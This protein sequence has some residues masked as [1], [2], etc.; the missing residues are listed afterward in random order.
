[1]LIFEGNYLLLDRAPWHDLAPLWD[2]TVS[3][4]I[5]E[6]MLTRRLVQ[7]WL[8]HGLSASEALARAESND[9]PNGRAVLRECRR[10]DYQLV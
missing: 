1:M 2:I 4:A 5:D 3:L 7:R 8:D 10:A 6:E 9:L